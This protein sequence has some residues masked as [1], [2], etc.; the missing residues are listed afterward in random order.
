MSVKSQI[1]GIIGKKISGVVVAE[2]PRPPHSQVFL[3]FDDGTHY[4]FYGQV[5][6]A[7]GLD[8]GGMEEAERYAKKCGGDV[9]RY[10]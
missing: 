2:N 10:T 4:E 7:S 3:V 8:R 9:V 1:Q 5:N 6:S